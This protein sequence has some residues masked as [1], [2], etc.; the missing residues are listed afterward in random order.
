M[1]SCVSFL[2]VLAALAFLMFAAYR[3]D[4]VFFIIG[5]YYATGLV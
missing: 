5:V 3:G 1:E 4:S 2:T